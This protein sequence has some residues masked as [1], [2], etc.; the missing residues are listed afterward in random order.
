MKNRVATIGLVAFLALD[1]ALVAL[2][3]RPGRAPTGSQPPATMPVTSMGTSTTSL[4]TPTE[5]TSTAPSATTSAAAAHVV[6]VD[7]MVSA[8]DRK[9]AWRVAGGACVAGGASVQVTTDGGQTWTKLKSPVRAIARVQALDDNRAFVIGSGADCGLKQFATND[10]GATWQSPTAVQ[11]GWSRRLD[12]PTQV[13]TPKADKA[14]A[15]NGEVVI[16]LAR[17]SLTQ[18]EVLCANGDVRATGDGGST[19]SDSGNAPG[20]VALGNYLEGDV[21]TTYAVRIVSACDGLQL[22]KVVKGR[23]ASIVSCVRA[24]RPKSGQVGLWVSAD[25]GWILNGSETWVAS[26]DL[27]SWRK[28]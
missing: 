27:R 22:V 24:S 18:A 14:V 21:L 17:V 12:E 11:N 9:I 2:A 23:N 10:Q 16:D 28:A 6:P 20:G 7:L 1:I 8:I 25:A 26:G 4:G 13:I 5:S 3:L 15:C 19:W